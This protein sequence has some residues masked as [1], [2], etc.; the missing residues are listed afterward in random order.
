M[1][2]WVCLRSVDARSVGGVNVSVC[3]YACEKV[4]MYLTVAYVCLRVRMCA[5]MCAC[6]Y[7]YIVFVC[8]VSSARGV[9]A[10]LCCIRTYVRVK[11]VSV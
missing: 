11:V 9:C 2:E 7:V 4:C 5:Y 10:C 1:C 3:V 8:R 6:I